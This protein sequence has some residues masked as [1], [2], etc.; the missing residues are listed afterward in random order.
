MLNK[1]HNKY[2]QLLRT[3]CIIIIIITIWRTSFILLLQSSSNSLD[4]GFYYYYYYLLL[5]G[6]QQHYTSFDIFAF[7]ILYTYR[8]Y[9]TF[10]LISI[11]L[12][13][14]HLNLFILN[15]QLPCIL[16]ISFV[17]LNNYNVLKS[18]L[19]GQPTLKIL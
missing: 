17:L 8:I 4:K 5:T 14:T 3:T 9:P 18:L 19:Y 7:S 13:L 2:I 15:S 1:I 16:R 6:E 12:P 10:T 11:T